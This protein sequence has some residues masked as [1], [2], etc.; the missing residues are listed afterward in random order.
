MLTAKHATVAYAGRVAAAQ[1]LA[2]DEAGKA[3]DV[4]DEVLRA[5]HQVGGADAVAAPG[6]SSNGKV[7]A[8]EMP[9]QMA[10]LAGQ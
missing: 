3:V 5:H 9:K 6:A 7:P 10:N 1:Q 4:K 8:I 2:T